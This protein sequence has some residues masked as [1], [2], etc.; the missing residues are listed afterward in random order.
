ME[1][2]WT[3]GICESCLK[4][5]HKKVKMKRQKIV[6]GDEEGKYVRELWVCPHC[7]ATK[8]L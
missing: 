8:R 7:G 1:Y 2:R 4:N 3:Y 5:S 6:S